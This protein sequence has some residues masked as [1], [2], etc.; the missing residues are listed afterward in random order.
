MLLGVQWWNLWSTDDKG[1]RDILKD[2]EI[3]NNWMG[4]AYGSIPILIN[5]N[6][7]PVFEGRKE[8]YIY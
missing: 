5:R 7:F 4:I 8:N 3:E 6:S 1:H 2:A